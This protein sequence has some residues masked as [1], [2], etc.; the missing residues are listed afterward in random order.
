MPSCICCEWFHYRLGSF[1]NEY[2][3]GRGGPSLRVFCCLA[4]AKHHRQRPHS[5]S[6]SQCLFLKARESSIP[7]R[8]YDL[9]FSING[10]HRYQLIRLLPLFEKSF[11]AYSLGVCSLLWTKICLSCDLRYANTT[12]ILLGVSWILLTHCA[13]WM[14]K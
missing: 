5:Y 3:L 1:L 4:W 6:W 2:Y 12:R 13:L 7:A 8:N 9:F 14:D 11:L 10:H